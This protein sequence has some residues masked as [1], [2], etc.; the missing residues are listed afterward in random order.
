MRIAPLAY[1]A[2]FALLV[3]CGEPE[4]SQAN[5]SHGKRIPA[6][7]AATAGSAAAAAAVPLGKPVS[8]ARAKKL[9]RDR[10]EGMEDIGDA[11]K[12]ISRELKAERPDP[13]KL[14]AN[15][16]I[17]ARLAPQ[18][19]GWFPPGTGPEVGKTRAKAEIW[20]KPRD[21]AAKT[22]TFQQAAKAFNAAARRGDIA[23]IRAAHA[24]LGKSCKACHD[25]YR[26]PED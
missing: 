13:A 16:A 10:H 24:D 18:V 14:R 3:A 4:A 11:F 26:E 22:R 20:N 19:S 8:G 6:P 25:P 12:L 15:A 21:F 17:I 5:N 9:M 7:S 1:T 2:G 23:T